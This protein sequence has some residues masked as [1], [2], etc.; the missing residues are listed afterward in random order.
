MTTSAPPLREMSMGS[1]PFRGRWP[2]VQCVGPFALVYLHSRYTHLQFLQSGLHIARVELDRAT[3]LDIRDLRITNED[4]FV[5]IPIELI[6]HRRDRRAL[7]RQLQPARAPRH[8]AQCISRVRL[9]DEADGA[10]F[11]LL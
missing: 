1:V 2:N 4:A 5:R 6:E 11:D 9:G 7:F 10:V 3:H 8:R